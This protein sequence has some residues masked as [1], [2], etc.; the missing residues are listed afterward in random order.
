MRET[1][2]NT[3]PEDFFWK[4]PQT[5][6]K[7]KRISRRGFLKSVGKAAVGFGLA[8]SLGKTAE[9]VERFAEEGAE[10]EEQKLRQDWAECKAEIEHSGVKDNIRFIEET[11]G[12]AA[13]A[14]VFKAKDDLSVFDQLVQ[15]EKEGQDLYINDKNKDLLK[16][17]LELYRQLWSKAEIQKVAQEAYRENVEKGVKI[18]GFEGASGLGKK[19]LDEAFAKLDPRWA[20]GNIS[21][22]QYDNTTKTNHVFGI[23]GEAYGEGLSGVF[24]SSGNERVTVYKSRSLENQQDYS[25][26]ISHEIGHHNDWSNTNALTIQERLKMLV[27]VTRRMDNPDSFKSPYVQVDI[28]ELYKDKSEGEIKLRQAQEYWAVLNERLDGHEEELRKHKPEDYV[29]VKKWRETITQRYGPVNPN[30]EQR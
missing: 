12:E 27:E 14:I 24:Y 21:A 2:P 7:D 28:P 11:Y 9:A 16:F 18:E 15:M 3:G 26:L 4:E 5:D 13:R 25:D 8:S 29:L 19:G 17:A 6:D 10:S 22:Y 23:A 30:N 1:G 20:R